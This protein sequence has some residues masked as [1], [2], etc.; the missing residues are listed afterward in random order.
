MLCLRDVVEIEAPPERVFD[1]FRHL[2]DN[3]RSWH[4]AH[5]SCTYVRG[6]G[7][8]DGAVLCAEE[9]LHGR[10]HRLKF[11][12]TEIEAGREFKYRI[13]PGIRGGFRMRPTDRGTELVA[14][15]F[16]GWSIPLIGGLIDRALE[17]LFPKHIAALRQHMKEE[18]LNLRALLSEEMNPVPPV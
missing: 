18:G 6:R 15:L 5:V 2:E 4:R 13:F 11:M 3:Y 14:E 1:W 17:S 8:E 16:L 9:Y 7:L 10:L 12:L